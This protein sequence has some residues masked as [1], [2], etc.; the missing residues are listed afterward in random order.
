[1]SRDAGWRFGAFA[2]KKIG[3]CSASGWARDR[4]RSAPSAV[5]RWARGM[6]LTH[7]VTLIG[8]MPPSIPRATT[9]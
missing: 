6:T 4:I 3:S 5:L 1:M 7:N 2:K 9:A 8:R